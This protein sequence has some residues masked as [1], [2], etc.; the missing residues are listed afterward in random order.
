[1]VR[2]TMVQRTV[3][4]RA[5]LRGTMDRFPGYGRVRRPAL[6]VALVVGLAGSLLAADPV[7]IGDLTTHGRGGLDNSHAGMVEAG[8]RVFF[9]AD[10]GSS[11]AELWSSDGTA[12]GTGLLLDRVAGLGSPD[13][14]GLRAADARV[15]F[16]VR[17]NDGPRFELWSSDGTAEGTVLLDRIP[18]LGSPELGGIA[19]VGAR[20]FF[21]LR[22][23][24]ERRLEL[25]TS[26]GTPEGTE[27]ARSFASGRTVYIP[28]SWQLQFYTRQTVAGDR[29][30]FSIDDGEH[31]SELWAADE[32]TGEPRLVADLNPGPE[33]S[34]PISLAA[35][36]DRVFFTAGDGQNAYALWVADGTRE[37][38]RRIRDISTTGNGCG[39]TFTGATDDL[40]FFL[41]NDG[42]HGLEPWV[43]DGS[44][45]GTGLVIDL[46]PGADEP[47]G[48]SFAALGDLM[49]IASP[50]SGGPR[51]FVSDGTASGTHVVYEGWS[52]TFQATASRLLFTQGDS[53]WSLDEA[54]ATR[55]I[56]GI[57][58]AWY[59]DWDEAWA[60]E[61]GGRVTVGEG[62]DR[63][64]VGE[65]VFFRGDDG[66]HGSEL[67]VSDGTPG[68]TAMVKDI[69]PGTSS[70]S[71]GPFAVLGDLVYFAAKGPEAGRELWVSDGTAKGTRRVAD[72]QT[73]TESSE[74]ALGGTFFDDVVIEVSNADRNSDPEIWV[75]DGTPQGTRPFGEKY[76]WLGGV[77]WSA[78]VGD[79]YFSASNDGSTGV[80]LWA[81]DGTRQGTRL[82]RDIMPGW[83][84]SA[85]EL[86][87]AAVGS[88][89]FRARESEHGRELWR[90]DGTE[91]G[92]LLVADLS[93]GFASTQFSALTA[94]GDRVFFFRGGELWVSDGTPS[95]T[96]RVR[97][98]NAGWALELSGITALA[99]R[100]FFVARDTERGREPWA[101]DG[102]PEGTYVLADIRAGPE[103]SK[104]AGFTRVDDG[105][106]FE[107][108]DG[109]G[110]G[111]WYSDGSPEGTRRVWYDSSASTSAPQ[112]FAAVGGRAFFTGT[113]LDYGRE[114]WVTDGTSAGTGLVRDLAAGPADSS[115][116]VLTGDGERVYFALYVAGIETWELWSSDGSDEG[117]LR[118]LDLGHVEGN[119]A[120]RA[121]AHRDTLFFTATDPFHGHELWAIPTSPPE[122]GEARFRRGDANGDGRV[123]IADCMH[124]LNHL[125]G[126]GPVAPCQDAANVRDTGSVDIGDVIVTA[127]FLFQGQ[128]FTGSGL[129]PPG[130][131][132]CGED[133]TV[134]NL[135]CLEYP[136]CR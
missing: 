29:L 75:S 68:G 123:N 128:A 121:F 89:F 43:S 103:G 109:V 73:G 17:P 94:V 47:H 60:W 8:G 118:M 105:V 13:L 108:H 49:V 112:T 92:T 58:V 38:T 67:W 132:A 9:V 78:R 98:V 84:G 64:T 87:V 4:R 91:A 62:G 3:V 72:I 95:G 66:D 1:M 131:F 22:T 42:V 52:D 113:N 104:S 114:L 81:S 97:A 119:P 126:G 6:L 77:P 85:P 36:G 20:L 28:D 32:D 12:E 69:H 129:P 90:S 70:S 19:T 93:P 54:G 21:W 44:A 82:V 116:E 51:I 59:Q 37:G 96:R 101:S 106:V 136:V 16:W 57:R 11:G 111:V 125:F 100:I 120:P 24:N 74:I 56:D 48:V 2:K 27:M 39:V 127:G 50:A 55:V 71:P 7:F 63:V 88:V 25:W 107:A 18:S 83:S 33:G 99:D 76:P 65:R 35:V 110:T 80:E 79:S 61:G 15:F 86:M 134:D 117:T 135:G 10:D 46:I 115:I 30:F 34:R 41:G 122:L 124:T 5:V 53:I 40:F 133:P 26:D 45:D 31:G 14:F 130:P 23:N 102:T